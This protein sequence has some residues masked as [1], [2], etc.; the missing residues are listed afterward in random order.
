MRTVELG[1]RTLGV[2]WNGKLVPVKIEEGSPPT[3]MKCF[4]WSK[5]YGALKATSEE[6]VAAIRGG[7]I[8]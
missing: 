2:S 7:S 8:A 1:I 6:S 5:P 3:I 4:N